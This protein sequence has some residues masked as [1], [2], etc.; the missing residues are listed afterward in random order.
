MTDR[1]TNRRSLLRMSGLAVAGTAAGIT[2][3]PSP[4]SSAERT[5]VVG[6]TD[7]A[8]LPGRVDPWTESTIERED[9]TP[10]A[11]HHYQPIASSEYVATAPIN[12]VIVPRSPDGTVYANGNRNGGGAEDDGLERVMSVLGDAGWTLDPEEYVRYA[13][14]RYVEQQATAAEAFYGTSGRH[15]VRCR[16]FEGVISMQVHEDSGARPHHTIDSY[17]EARTVIETLFDE[18][19]WAVPPGV[20]DLGNERGPDHD[21]TATVIAEVDR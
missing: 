3:L 6:A 2:A 5:G 20:I 17:A 18:E 8:D 1:I 12:V 16:S 21:G 7:V 19:G 9:E 15:H 14:D 4:P 13:R 11:R 10:I